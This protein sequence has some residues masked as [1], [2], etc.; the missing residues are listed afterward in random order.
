MTMDGILDKSF[1]FCR[2]PTIMNSVLFL[3]NVNLFAI[4][5]LFTFSTSVFHLCSIS[6]GKLP[7]H[8]MLVSS[9]NTDVLVVSKQLGRLFTERRKSKGPTFDPP[10]DSTCSAPS[11]RD[12]VVDFTYLFPLVNV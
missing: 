5:F 10:K 11:I 1:N 12:R 7:R 3:F 8:D 4:S 6:E 9:P 2:D